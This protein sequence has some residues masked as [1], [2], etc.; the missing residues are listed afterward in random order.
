MSGNEV[1]LPKALLALK[2]YQVTDGPWR[3]NI[4]GVEGW[5]DNLARISRPRY[6]VQMS[7]SNAIEEGIAFLT[8]IVGEESL[9]GNESTI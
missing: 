3:A 6:E 1:A 4:L 8:K 7:N 5:M 2:S 9:C